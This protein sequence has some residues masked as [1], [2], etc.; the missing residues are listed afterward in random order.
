MPINLAAVDAYL[1]VIMA[2][3]AEAARLWLKDDAL[4]RPGTGLLHAGNPNPSS[5]AGEY[6]ASQLENLRGS[7][8][9][10]SVGHLTF[11]LGSFE[12]LNAQGHA[13]AVK[14]ESL[15]ES[16]GGRHWLEKA[17]AEGELAHVLLTGGS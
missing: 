3:R 15:P 9:A 6:P 4:N 5:S 10:R 12:D 13:E 11:A 17:L 1:E 14:L 8:D 2:E 7:I 16:K